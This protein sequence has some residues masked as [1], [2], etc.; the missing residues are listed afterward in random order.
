MYCRD[1]Q[2]ISKESVSSRGASTARVKGS[3]VV[4][5]SIEEF[6]WLTRFGTRTRAGQDL[7]ATLRC[8]DSAEG[9]YTIG[10]IEVEEQGS[11]I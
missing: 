10:I 3:S 6:G 2:D 1:F 4:R 11:M 5:A 8:R 9:L 7:V